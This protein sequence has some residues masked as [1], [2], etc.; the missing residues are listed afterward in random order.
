[1]QF[2]TALAYVMGMFFIYKGLMALKQYGQE[3]TQMSSQHELKGPLIFLAV[4]AALLY[5]PSSV[6]VGLNT[7]WMNPNPYGYQL[8]ATDQWETI[9]QDTYVI[10]QLIGTIAFIRGLVMLT[11]LGGQHAQPG[12]LGKAMAHI[13]A[14]IFCIN[15]YEFITVI[16]NT[17]TLSGS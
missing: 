15:L 17:L 4:G 8:V 1:M 6:Q 2:V 13:I 5:L 12:Q 11:H 9:R 10:I 7:F 16:E 14:G 3:R